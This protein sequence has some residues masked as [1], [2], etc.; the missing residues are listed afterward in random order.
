MAPAI[1][2]A[3][4]I[5]FILRDMLPL[6]KSS[7]FGIQDATLHCKSE[8]RPCKFSLSINALVSNDKQAH[9]IK[10][11]IEV[12]YYNSGNTIVKCL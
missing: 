7:F 1:N 9:S 6:K 11:E 10:Y 5:C 4:A 12:Y 2:E 8:V 3:G